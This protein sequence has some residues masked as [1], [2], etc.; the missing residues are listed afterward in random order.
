MKRK[1]PTSP[2]RRLQLE[3]YTKEPP[4]FKGKSAIRRRT[5]Y[6]IQRGDYVRV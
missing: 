1:R 3:R 6:G 4:A 5:W 2:R